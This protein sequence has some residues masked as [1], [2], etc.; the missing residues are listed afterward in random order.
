MEELLTEL[1]QIFA[2]YRRDLEEC[3][4]KAKPTDGLFGF[5]HG[6]KDDACHARLDNRVKENI[7]K[8]RL[9]RPSPD[10]AERAVRLLHRS[11]IPAW[12]LSAQWMLRAVER[13]SLPL[14]P[15]LSPEAAAVLLKE[16]ESR[17]RPWDRLPVQKEICKALKARR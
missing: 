10:E 6:V 16:Y 2:D 4:K 12:P 5:G 1:E 8:I 3:E 17:Y 13:H 9:L 7:E 14:I 11:D 15:F